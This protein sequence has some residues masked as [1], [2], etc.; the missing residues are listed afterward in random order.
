MQTDIEILRNMY[1]NDDGHF[2]LRKFPGDV[3]R[4]SEGASYVNNVKDP[5]TGQWNEVPMIYVYRKVG[6]R[7]LAFSKGTI[8]EC[9][10]TFIRLS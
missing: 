3:F 4:I 10:Q 1:G 5:E 6:V 9:H 2:G 7:W 8:R